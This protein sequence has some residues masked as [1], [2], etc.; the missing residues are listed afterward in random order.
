MGTQTGDLTMNKGKLN[1]QRGDEG[2][3][4]TRKGTCKQ[5]R[6]TRHKDTYPHTEGVRNTED[7]D[8]KRTQKREPKLG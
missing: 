7:K 6:E 5:K 8:A 3:A 1:T 2:S 4:N